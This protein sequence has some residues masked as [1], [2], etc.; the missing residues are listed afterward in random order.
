MPERRTIRSSMP[1][2]QDH[3]PDFL[4]E[5]REFWQRRSPR[6]LSR[7]DAR[8][9]ADNVSGFF[10]VLQEWDASERRHGTQDPHTAPLEPGK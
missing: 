10:R 7:E 6:R 8:Q 1:P 4:D 5:T 3:E 2:R 9:I